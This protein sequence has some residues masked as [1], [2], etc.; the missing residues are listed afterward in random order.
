MEIQIVPTMDCEPPQSE[1]SEYAN[2]K[3]SSGPEDYAESRQSIAGY[4]AV[5]DQ[6]EYMPTLFVHPQV[7]MR[8]REFF[9][10]LR[11]RGVCLGLHLHPYKMDESYRHDLGAHE[12]STQREILAEATRRW[13]DALG[14]HPEYF[15]PGVFSANDCTYGLLEDLGYSGGSVSS[16]GRVLPSAA[17]VWA[18]AEYYPH[19]AHRGLRQL[20]GEADFADVPMTVDT[21]SPIQGQRLSA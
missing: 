7:A 15:R 17:A 9:L 11:D 12:Y 19:R 18:G 8:Q 14:Y 20:D 4:I 2:R 16:P 3:S 5:L 6:Y 13:E 10:D 1:I 21:D